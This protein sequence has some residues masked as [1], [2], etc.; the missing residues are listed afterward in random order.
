MI[1][2]RET[3][4]G[5]IF[6]GTVVASVSTPSTRMRTRISRAPVLGLVVDVGSAALGGLGDD[7]VN[8]LDDRRVVG[9]LL[10]VDD[11]LVV[12]ARRVLLDR[13]G[14]RILEPVHAHDQRS[15]VLGRG[16]RRTDV[17]VGQQS[18]V[19]DRQ[20]VGRVGHGEQ[21]GVLVEVG[22]GHRAVALGRGGAQ[23]V[24]GRHV[25]LED[26]EVEVVEP[27][28]LGD[29]AGELL[30]GD[31]LLVEQHALRRHAGCAR[32][33]DGPGDGLLLGEAE[34]DHHVGELPARAAAPGGRRDAGEGFGLMRFADA[35]RPS[36]ARRINSTGAARPVNCSKLRAPWRTSSSRPPTT[37]TRR[38]R[39]ACT[40]GVSVSEYTRSTTHS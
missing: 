12:R 37:R 38:A 16:H 10:E 27:V 22:D 7:R 4:P 6:L 32:G 13:L 36:T 20:H 31:G 18:H 28:A 26:A 11:L 19:V 14:D 29:R 23:Q 1:L 39:A 25:D 5:T 34:L 17:E 30:G 33:L 2:M 35:H 15:D 8:E 3:T 21:Q 24:G 9:R 40:S